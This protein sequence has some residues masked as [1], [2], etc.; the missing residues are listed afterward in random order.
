MAKVRRVSFAEKEFEYYKVL[1]QMDPDPSRR[2]IGNPEILSGFDHWKYTFFCAGEGAGSVIIKKNGTGCDVVTDRNVAGAIK[3]FADYLFLNQENWLNDMTL[4]YKDAE[5]IVRGWSARAHRF[6]MPKPVAFASD[7][8][9]AMRRMDFDPVPCTLQELRTHCPE[10]VSILERIRG[11]ESD[12]ATCWDL[13]EAWAARIG[14]LYDPSASRKQSVWMYGPANGGKSLIA[15]FISWLV[16]NN[17]SDLSMATITRQEYWKAGLAGKRVVSVME[18]A[19]GWIDRP[20]FKAITGDRRHT[21]RQ[22]WGAETSIELDAMF[23][24][25]SNENPEIHRDAATMFR[26][27]PVYMPGIP[28]GER[29]A[30]QELLDKLK[31]GARY[32]VGY[33]QGVWAKRRR[34]D[35]SISLG[36]DYIEH[37]VEQGEADYHSFLGSVLERRNNRNKGINC[38]DF[39]IMCGWHGFNHQDIKRLKAMLERDYGSK[40]DRQTNGERIFFY[41][42]VYWSPAALKEFHDRR[43]RCMGEVV[44]QYVYA[45]S[46]KTDP[47]TSQDE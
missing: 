11:K 12:E 35:N 39:K 28:D 32:I 46:D 38:N 3:T 7:S 41:P 8:S 34:P 25:Y 2:E 9:V 44:K 4:T 30:E 37:H 26:L 42:N 43:V 22:I 21:V 24:F 15:T 40:R 6:P 16:G 1:D 19:T 17:A 27:V 5:N 36:N 20:D 10:F 14:S 13:A 29:M 47:E 45:V 31:A 23:F 33:C 18:A